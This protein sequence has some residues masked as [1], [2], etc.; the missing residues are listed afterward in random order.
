MHDRRRAQLGRECYPR[1]NCVASELRKE[2]TVGQKKMPAKFDCWHS[3]RNV[4]ACGAKK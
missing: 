4:S 3:I 2:Q 1:G